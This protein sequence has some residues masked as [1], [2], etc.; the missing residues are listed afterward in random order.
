MPSF[1]CALFPVKFS[2]KHA[3]DQN[4]RS[5]CNADTSCSSL[6]HSELIAARWSNISTAVLQSDALH[7]SQQWRLCALCSIWALSSTI[8][9][10]PQVEYSISCIF[11]IFRIG[12]WQPVRVSKHPKKT[13]ICS[14]ETWGSIGMYSL[15]IVYSLH[16]LHILYNLCVRRVAHTDISRSTS[17]VFASCTSSTIKDTAQLLSSSTWRHQL[18]SPTPSPTWV[19]EH[20]EHKLHFFAFFAY[21]AWRVHVQE[22]FTSQDVPFCSLPTMATDIMKELMPDA[23]FHRISLRD[24]VFSSK[25]GLEL[26]TG[27]CHYYW[28][29]GATEKWTGISNWTFTTA[30]QW[31]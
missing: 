29:H 11:C 6:Q 18:P 5:P 21:T 2:S 8:E 12:V 9:T 20:I 31:L 22:G 25:I 1:Q 4:W 14:L 13:D 23:V 16:I 19:L 27:P 10:A 17:K 26:Q 28:N 3:Y 15:H 24:V 30:I 7:G